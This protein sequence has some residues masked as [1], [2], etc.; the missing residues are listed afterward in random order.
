MMYEQLWA[1]QLLFKE[2]GVH[3]Y[4]FD[5]RVVSC[6]WHSPLSTFVQKDSYNGL[7]DATSVQTVWL[8]L[9]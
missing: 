9:R 6:L 8:H 7:F 1:V 4:L 2:L 5:S 3:D